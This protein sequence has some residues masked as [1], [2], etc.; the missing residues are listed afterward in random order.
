MLDDA[1]WRNGSAEDSKSSGLGSTPSA[2]ANLN[3]FIC[4][5]GGIGRH[6]RLKIC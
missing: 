3:S 4:G 6:H 2:A 1:V 5:Y